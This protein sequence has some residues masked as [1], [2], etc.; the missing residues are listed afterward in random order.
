MA[1]RRG[2]DAELLQIVETSDPGALAP[3]P[4]IVEDRRGGAELGREIGGINPAVRGID[5]DRA[6]GLVGDPRDAVGGDDRRGGH[7]GPPYNKSRSIAT[8]GL[9]AGGIA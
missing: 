9:S 4:G 7:G 1:D 3:D 6:P 2:R 5:D 8:S